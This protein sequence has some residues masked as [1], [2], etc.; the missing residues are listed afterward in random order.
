MGNSG[1]KAWGH[2][3]DEAAA[4]SSA[5]VLAASGAGRGALGDTTNTGAGRDCASSQEKNSGKTTPCDA[6][7]ECLALPRRC[8]KALRGTGRG[9]MRAAS[10][11]AARGGGSSPGRTRPP[12]ASWGCREGVTG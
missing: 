3:W 8:H 11:G 1:A 6:L 7:S 4:A 12:K 5:E 10:R 2:G 9:G